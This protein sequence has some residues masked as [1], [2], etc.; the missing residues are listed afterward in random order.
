MQMLDR[1]LLK[2]AS[3]SASYPSNYLTLDLL[4]EQLRYIA[5]TL[6]VW[7][8][9]IERKIYFA[10]LSVFLCS[11]RPEWVWRDHIHIFNFSAQF[12]CASCKYSATFSSSII[13]P[14]P[15]PRNDIQC[16]LISM[17]VELFYRLRINS[18]QNLLSETTPNKTLQR[19]LKANETHHSDAWIQILLFA[20]NMNF[21]N[22]FWKTFEPSF[23][24]FC[25]KSRPSKGIENVL[26]RLFDFYGNQAFGHLLM[27]EHGLWRCHSNFSLMLH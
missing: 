5:S 1:L 21:M 9:G 13:M 17:P 4:E 14:R 7:R 3:P 24:K 20:L 6:I 23:Q 18:S 19:V 15:A 11:S 12:S 26:K 16:V 8:L 25:R 2:D 22:C 10:I 27:N